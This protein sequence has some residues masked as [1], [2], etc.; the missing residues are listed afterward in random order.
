MKLQGF[1]PGDR[2][3]FRRHKRG[4]FGRWISLLQLS[5]AQRGIEAYVVMEE[6]RAWLKR[7]PPLAGKRAIFVA[8]RSLAQCF[9]FLF[10]SWHGSERMGK[11]MDVTEIALL[12]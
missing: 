3:L 5:M 8:I 12:S 1:C 2:C 6:R 10:C 4:T 9:S 7:L 11:E